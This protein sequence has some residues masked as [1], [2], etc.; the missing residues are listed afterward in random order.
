MD[1]DFDDFEFQEFD[2]QSMEGFDDFD[3]D[4]AQ[5]DEEEDDISILIENA[6]YESKNYEDNDPTSAVTGFQKVLELDTNQSEWSFKAIKHLCLC[7][8][9][10]GRFD[11]LLDHYYRLLTFASSSVVSRNE[12]ERAV[13]TIM[14]SLNI[15]S[16]DDSMLSFLEQVY[17]KTFEKLSSHSE[18]ERFCQKTLLKLGN[19]Y[20]S[21]KQF[22]QAKPI[23]ARLYDSLGGEDEHVE[24]PRK[25]ATLL[26]VVALD[27]TV[28]TSLKEFKKVRKLNSQAQKLK[29][30]SVA[31][32]YIWGIIASASA[33]MKMDYRDFDGSMDSWKEAF[34]SFDESGSSNRM[35]ALQFLCLCSLLSRSDVDIFSAPEIK[36]YQTSPEISVFFDLVSAF[37]SQDIDGFEDALSK[38]ND[39]S[40]TPFFE[41]LR[42]SIKTRVF[43]SFVSSFSRVTLD[44]IALKLKSSVTEVTRLV[45]KAIVS[46][47]IK[48]KIDY[49]FGVLI[50]EDDDEVN[51]KVRFYKAIQEWA[52]S[53]KEKVR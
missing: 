6:Y 42:F 18:F 1:D 4:M 39:E 30:Y 3:F 38:I 31:H 29:H 36:P 44:Y 16:T 21:H 46:G 35:Q 41:D 40:M 34:K 19:F 20:V 8:K 9:K 25:A 51:P 23:I 10:L 22:D 12:F 26:E 2:D 7:F 27:L 52:V 14:D 5:P 32:P 11:E 17:Q 45:M 43:L 37:N 53:I 49:R 48:G 50:L 24:D 33:R 15:L 28:S 47:H 13:S